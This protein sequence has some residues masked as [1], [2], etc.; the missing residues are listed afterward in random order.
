MG[1]LKRRV[2]TGHETLAEWSPDDLGSLEAA[3]QLF[4]RELEAG[5]VAVRAE[6]EDN[7]PVTELPADAKVV[8]LTMPMGG[9]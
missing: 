9:G 7:Q 1:V 2:L 5:Y 8:I 6:D 3:Q 4:H